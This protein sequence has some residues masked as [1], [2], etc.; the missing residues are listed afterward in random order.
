MAGKDSAGSE[1]NLIA[2]GTVVEGKI[3]TPGSLRIDGRVVGDIMATQNASIG[4]TGDVTGNVSAKN[5]TVAGKINGSIV[6]LE[7]LV[8]EPQAVVCG[9]I[10]AAKLVVNEGAK[11]DGQCQMSQAKDMPN[12]VELR[13]DSR[14]AEER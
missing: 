14:R 7:K 6:A 3:R 12:L 10:R 5:V 11:Y 1:L 4:A 8:F 13:Q 2:A 9:D